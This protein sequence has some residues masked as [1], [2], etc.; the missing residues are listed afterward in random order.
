MPELTRVI[1]SKQAYY[2]ITNK[3][4]SKMFNQ[5]EKT[6]SRHIN[7]PAL[8]TVQELMNYVKLLHIEEGVLI[9][10]LYKK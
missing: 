9:N 5:T 4:I 10:S 7:N 3:K 2:G 1:K 8:M 6:V